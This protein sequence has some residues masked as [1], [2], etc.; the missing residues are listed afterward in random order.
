MRV[1]PQKGFF[2]VQLLD[3]GI[4]GCLIRAGFKRPDES[5]TIAPV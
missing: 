3:R 1:T 5:K 2:E 4:Q